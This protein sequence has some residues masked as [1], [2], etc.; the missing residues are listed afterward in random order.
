M[1]DGADISSIVCDRRFLLTTSIIE[2]LPK[3][4]IAILILLMF[5]LWFISFSV[6]ARVRLY[7]NRHR[8]SLIEQLPSLGDASTLLGLVFA[9]MAIVASFAANA[10]IGKYEPTLMFLSGSALFLFFYITLSRIPIYPWIVHF[11]WAS[12]SSGWYCLSWSPFAL[13]DVLLPTKLWRLILIFP[14]VLLLIYALT[15][16]GIM[17]YS[18]QGGTMLT[19]YKCPTH[20]FVP[21]TKNGCKYCQPSS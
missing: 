16:I 8:D 7:V 20:G 2:Q 4:S 14:P 18:K 19:W 10:N 15:S 3:W 6:S 12:I 21:R 1:I 9:S 11:S 17:W 13:I 5:I